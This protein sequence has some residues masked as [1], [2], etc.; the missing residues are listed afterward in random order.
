MTSF[1]RDAN[2]VPVVGGVLST[3]GTTPTPLEVDSYGN[4]L[5]MPTGFGIRSYDYI[6]YTSG[7]TTNTY[8]F[9]TGG[10]SGTTVATIVI[11]YTGTDKQIFSNISKT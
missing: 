8:V 5:V 11:T 9:K 2:R 7:D 10:P 3:N 4:L 1:P 6:S